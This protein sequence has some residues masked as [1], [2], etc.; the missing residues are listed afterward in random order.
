MQTLGQA[1]KEARLKKKMSV[2]GAARA[3]GVSSTYIAELESGQKANPTLIPLG[4]LAGVY[5]CAIVLTITRNG[6]AYCEMTYDISE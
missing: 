5:N 1:L 4:E 6:I 2:R 3:S